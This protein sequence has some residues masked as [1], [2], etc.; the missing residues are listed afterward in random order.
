MPYSS[1]CDFGEP[2]GFPSVWAWAGK[3]EVDELP[4]PLWA[5]GDGNKIIWVR[6]EVDASRRVLCIK[7]DRRFLR[8]HG[9]V[10]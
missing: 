10:D 6:W 7:I 8:R 1:N 3:A 2:R 4:G 5:T 9:G